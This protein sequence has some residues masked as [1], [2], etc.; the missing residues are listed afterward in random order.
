MSEFAEKTKKEQSEN[1]STK[2]VNCT[3][4]PTQLKE[5]VEQSTGLSLDDVRVH[6]NSYLPEKLDALA[7]TCGNQVEISPGQENC[8]PH[9]LGHVVQ[10]KLGLVRANAMHASGA[11]LNTEEALEHQADEIGAGKKIDITARPT[12]RNIIQRKL[13]IRIF[14]NIIFKNSDEMKKNSAKSQP[15][16]PRS[17][18]KDLGYL[19]IYETSAETLADCFMQWL[20]CTKGEPPALEKYGQLREKIIAKI[21]SM[22]NKGVDSAPPEWVYQKHIHESNNVRRLQENEH[23][24]VSYYFDSIEDF[25]KYLSLYVDKYAIQAK[26]AAELAELTEQ[27]LLADDNE[28]IPPDVVSPWLKI[29]VV[30]TGAGDAIVMTL[31]AGYLIVDLGSNLNILLNY[32]ALRK[33]RHDDAAPNNRGISLEGNKTCIVITHGDA[34]HKGCSMQEFSY[35]EDKLLEQVIIGYKQ[36]CGA[37]AEGDEKYIKLVKLL[38]S[39]RF[40]VCDMSESAIVNKNSDSL[41]IARRLGDTE[42]VILCGDQEPKNLKPILDGISGVSEYK[43][44]H[45]FVKVPHHGSCENNTPAVMNKFSE[46]GNVADFVVSAGKLYEHPTAG[47]FARGR[48][49]YAQGTEVRYPAFIPTRSRKAEGPGPSSNSRVFY[50]QNLNTGQYEIIPGSVAYK[51][52]GIEHVTYS[53]CYTDESDEQHNEIQTPDEN[54]LAIIRM[55]NNIGDKQYQNDEISEDVCNVFS[56]LNEPQQVYFLYG[57]GDASMINKLLN[58]V[59]IQDLKFEHPDLWQELFT[60]AWEPIDWEQ[61]CFNIMAITCSDQFFEE[62]YDEILDIENEVLRD[63]FIREVIVYKRNSVFFVNKVLEWNSEKGKIDSDNT[64]NILCE[65]FCN[66]F[67]SGQDDSEGDDNICELL[68]ELELKTQIGVIISFLKKGVLTF[69]QVSAVLELLMDKMAEMI[70]EKG[71]DGENGQFILSILDSSFFIDLFHRYPKNYE[72]I[73]E[74]Y[75]RAELDE[76]RTAQRDWNFIKQNRSGKNLTVFMKE[77]GMEYEDYVSQLDPVTFNEDKEAL[78]VIAIEQKENTLEYLGEFFN[79]C[80]VYNELP[81]YLVRFQV[82]CVQGRLP[83]LHRLLK[84]GNLKP[85]VIIA[86]YDYLLK[87]DSLILNIARE[88][89]MTLV[90]DFPDFTRAIILMSP[91][92]I[93]DIARIKMFLY[94]AL[95]TSNRKLMED[96][97]AQH[98]E[99]RKKE[100]ENILYELIKEGSVLNMDQLFEIA[101]EARNTDPKYLAALF[102]ICNE[103]G[104]QGMLK[105][106]LEQILAD[107]NNL[108]CLYQLLAKNYLEPKVVNE[109][110]DLLTDNVNIWVFAANDPFT[111]LGHFPLLLMQILSKPLDAEKADFYA[112]LQLKINLCY[113]L[114]EKCPHLLNTFVEN[115]KGKMG[116]EM[117]IILENIEAYDNG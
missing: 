26:K 37:R 64:N 108:K 102:E 18:R 45:M 55:K 66:N 115:Y 111:L 91:D 114:L 24:E 13:F 35:G 78:F 46:I 7:Y 85:P 4:I 56:I 97:I 10:Q 2:Q 49:L 54:V 15:K 34:D 20:I 47:M 3:G 65:L 79:I 43:T 77:L 53:K 72:E 40:H 67:F 16:M 5:R 90:K 60:E 88:D 110:F 100:A 38:K 98:L 83:Y 107:M 29:N 27:D 63:R 17:V 105:E 86:C 80:Y 101:Y 52:N 12:I 58:S 31:P 75:E 116:K 41:V 25:Y 95:G 36:Y 113:F 69:D 103:H 109:C 51:S 42:A 117:V 92:K 68:G 28:E 112:R 22:V 6:Y 1:H 104:D 73:Y 94:M 106:Y 82:E 33:N 39:G 59:N 57:L 74:I 32:L 8:L 89:P 84:E 87:E 11:A 81:T 19:E 30:N 93:S 14:R 99:V 9:E 71:M 44:D 62:L 48:R 21:V 50:T 96:L 76:H 23:K 61:N 70:E